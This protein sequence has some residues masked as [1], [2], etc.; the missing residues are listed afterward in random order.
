LKFVKQAVKAGRKSETVI[1]SHINLLLVGYLIK[2][3][4]PE[5]KVLLIAHGIEV[6][7][8]FP[9]WKVRML[10]KVDMVLAVSEFTRQKMVSLY[11]LDHRKTIVLN[12]CLDPFLTKRLDPSIKNKLKE[13]YGFDENDDVLFTLT[14]LKST[15]QYKG[16]DKVISALPEVLKKFPLVKYLV[17]GKY[18]ES[19]KERL[20]EIIRRLGLQQ[21]VIFSGFAKDE[22]IEKLF[23][24]ADVYVMPSSGEGFGIVFIEAMFYGKPVIAGNVDG[25][26][27]ALDKGKFG[28]L[29]DPSSQKEIVKAIKT[30]LQDRKTYQ[31]ELA[32]VQ[33]KFGFETYKNHLLQILDL[34]KQKT[35]ENVV[36]A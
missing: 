8:P 24:L 26:V 22:E 10:K 19:E 12:N 28:L 3:F 31:P 34:K 16:Y 33:A 32:A 18:D 36:G 2:L 9:G 13:E 17:T 14:R 5:T 11:S 30:V 20:D 21:K 29:V 6:W 15:E 4:S 7:N 1:L 27:D 25:S 35:D 23:T